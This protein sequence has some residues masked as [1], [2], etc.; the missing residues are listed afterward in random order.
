[1]H[2]FK[3]LF[4]NI[5]LNFEN[6]HFRRKRYIMPFTRSNKTKRLRT[7]LSV[8]LIMLA[9]NISTMSNASSALITVEKND[10]TKRPD[11]TELWQKWRV[12]IF[13][14][15]KKDTLKKLEL[16]LNDIKTKELGFSEFAI[17]LD[18]HGGN[19]AEAI[20]IADYIS[21]NAITTVIDRNAIC[22]SACAFI[23][24]A[25]REPQIEGPG[26]VSRYLHIQGELGFHA[27]FLKY[28]THVL[29]EKFNGT[30]RDV[31]RAYQTG[32]VQVGQLLTGYGSTGTRWPPSLVGRVLQIPP[33]EFL[34]IKTVD[35]AGRWNISLLGYK[36]SSVKINN[37][38]KKFLTCLNAF[39]WSDEE[40]WIEYSLETITSDG[41][42]KGWSTQVTETSTDE[43]IAEAYDVPIDNLNVLGCSIFRFTDTQ[44]W[45]VD[46]N[47]GG[48]PVTHL[49]TENPNKK[50]KELD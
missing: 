46:T 44:E 30:N 45:V 19:F 23:F 7:I 26:A 31:F 8:V 24:M 13:G 32:L 4:Q 16:K 5:Y 14:E 47:P 20:K 25:G 9:Y 18:S 28:D 22:L 2:F 6:L 29:D 50:L 39:R 11:L 37:N 21:S 3:Y 1:M 49:L 43:G 10:A 34:N 38:E 48:Q 40:K 33:D 35:E 17:F 41:Y 15:I 36:T 12:N 42:I 27:P